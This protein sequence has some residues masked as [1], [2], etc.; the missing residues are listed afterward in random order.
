MYI[1]P[2]DNGDDYLDMV[3]NLAYLVDES[4]RPLEIMIESGQV[5]EE[6]ML[7]RLPAFISLVNTIGYLRGRES[8]FTDI[9]PRETAHEQELIRETEKSL[10]NRLSS[11]IAYIKGTGNAGKASK[12]LSSY[13]LI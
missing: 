4:L 11:I 5:D 3:G 8:I 1:K 9:R 12:I 13:F 7:M 6:M 10:E 2:F